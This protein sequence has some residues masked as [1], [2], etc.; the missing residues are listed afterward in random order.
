MRNWKKAVEKRGLRV[1][2]EKTKLMVTGRDDRRKYES[3][4]ILLFVM[5]QWI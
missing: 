3:R 2:M 5:R 1:N 4:T